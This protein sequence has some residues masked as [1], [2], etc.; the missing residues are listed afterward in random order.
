[1]KI[2]SFFAYKK[3]ENNF[4]YEGVTQKIK[5]VKF[6]KLSTNRDIG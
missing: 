2:L 4:G 1:M 3:T 6:I 5:L